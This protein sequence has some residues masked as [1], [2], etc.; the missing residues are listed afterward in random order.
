MKL[1]K[2]QKKY[3]KV[4]SKIE[5]E[6]LACYDEHKQYLGNLIN[7]LIDKGFKPLVYS[8]SKNGSRCCEIHIV[9]VDIVRPAE[10]N[11]NYTVD[12]YEG[13][14]IKYATQS[15]KMFLFFESLR[16]KYTK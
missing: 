9:P 5:F 16:I 13:F 2:E 12:F 6:K 11:K 14:N 4:E 1:S 8:F 10:P 7:I 15:N 3:H